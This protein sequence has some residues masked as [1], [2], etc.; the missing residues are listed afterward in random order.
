M[1][2]NSK[3][4]LLFITLTSLFILLSLHLQ[5]IIKCE[6]GFNCILRAKCGCM[7]IEINITI[8]K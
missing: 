8:T 4:T 3:K 6:T 7:Y 2:D 5:K 1:L